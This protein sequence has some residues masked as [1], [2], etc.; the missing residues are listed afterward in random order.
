RHGPACARS[1]AQLDEDRAVL[2][3]GGKAGHAHR[4]IVDIGAGGHVPAPGVPGADHDG[5]LE[6]AVTERPAAMAARVVD[7]VVGPLD[8][9]DRERAA[10]GL[11][12]PSLAGG[13][14]PC[15]GHADPML[16]AHGSLVAVPPARCQAS[17]DRRL[18]MT[19]YGGLSLE[20]RLAPRACALL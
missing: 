20:V 6:I 15:R 5:A 8:V 12:D 14:L 10:A 11:H 17:V 13:N 19:A 1:G 16:V 7:R 2:H 18:V 4:G 3:A 9:E